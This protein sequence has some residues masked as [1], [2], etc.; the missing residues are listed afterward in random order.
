MHRLRMQLLLLVIMSMHCASLHSMLSVENNQALAWNVITA[1]SL[2][3]KDYKTYRNVAMLNKQ[4]NSMIEDTYRSQKKRIEKFIQSKSVSIT[5][6]RSW[7]KDFTRCAWM[8]IS[9]DISVNCK[10]LQ[11][12]V[13]G[14][15]DD[16]KRII[17]SSRL[18]R[19]FCC[20]IFE[21]DVRPFFD[22]DGRACFH[23]YGKVVMVG[24]NFAVAQYCIDLIGNP[25]R[26]CCYFGSR[27]CGLIMTLIL[28]Y[29]V[30][31][32]AFLRSK[33]I[34]Y[35]EGNKE[36]MYDSSKV[37]CRDGVV[38]PE[39]YKVFKKSIEIEQV[40]KTWETPYYSAFTSYDSLN[41]YTKNSIDY[42]CEKQQQE[43]NNTNSQEK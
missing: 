2:S 6:H 39:N 30:L 33:L 32:K 10:K 36:E 22:K 28:Q 20:P 9:D 7:N 13:V 18:W 43:K 27:K 3:C 23:G 38:L 42:H 14:S 4:C 12:T 19:E 31:I 1:Y 17:S 8:R 11:L 41:D 16:G 24:M 37:Y 34:C 26:Y 21:D 25:Q 35:K 40:E 29:P 5:G 15:I